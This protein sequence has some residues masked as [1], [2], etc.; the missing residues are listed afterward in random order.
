MCVG[1]VND[2]M[3]VKELYDDYG[4]ESGWIM[5]GGVMMD[6]IVVVV[7]IVVF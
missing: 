3:V 7:Y 1:Y 5:Y 4:S 2:V 6:V